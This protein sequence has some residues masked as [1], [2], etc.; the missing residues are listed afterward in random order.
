MTGSTTPHPPPPDPL[1][2][3]SYAVTTEHLS[4]RYPTVTAVDDLDL[5]LV[6]GEVT[7]FVG[8]NGAGKTTTIRMLLGLITPSEGT[9]SVLGEPIDRPERYLPRVGAMIEGPAF[10]PTMSGRLNLRV[11]CQLGGIP[12]HRIDEVLELVALT[13][14]QGD[15]FKTYSLG[16]KQRLG[17]AAALLPEPELLILDE[18]TN[19][20]DPAGI[21]ETRAILRDLGDRG[22]TV[23]VSSHLLGEI[24]AICDELVLIANGRLRFQGPVQELTHSRHTRISAQPELASDLDALLRLC[25][26]AALPASIVDGQLLVDAPAERSAWLNR[27]AFEAGITLKALNVTRPNLEEAFFAMTEPPEKATE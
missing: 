8:P 26:S 25:E 24:E 27:A 14:R 4:K 5:R 21:R 23:F 18:P 3:G 9:G 10:Y 6:Q 13:D 7:G 2:A 11:L 12:E 15:A 20:L 22:I 1:V 16:M 17:L 19:G